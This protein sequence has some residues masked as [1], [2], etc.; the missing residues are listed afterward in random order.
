[1]SRGGS[2]GTRDGFFFDA[3]AAMSR[4]RWE[5]VSAEKIERRSMGKPVSV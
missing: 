4:S 5:I 3:L 2:A 1:M